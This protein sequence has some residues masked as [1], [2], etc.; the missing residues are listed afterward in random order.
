MQAA[1]EFYA[2]VGHMGNDGLEASL[3]TGELSRKVAMLTAGV[4]EDVY[5]V[6][7]QL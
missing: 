5:N 2:L 4:A 1:L 3:R 7:E 6:C